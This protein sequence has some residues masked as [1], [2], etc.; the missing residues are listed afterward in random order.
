MEKLLGK[1]DKGICDIC[2]HF[3]V[4]SLSKVTDSIN[5]KADSRV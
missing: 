3:I 1:N 4:K 5:K 2:F